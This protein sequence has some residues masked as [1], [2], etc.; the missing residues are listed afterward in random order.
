M[1]IIVSFTKKYIVHQSYMLN[2]F[3]DVLIY[4]AM[5][6]IQD[7]WNLTLSTGNSAMLRTP[8]WGEI[9]AKDRTYYLAV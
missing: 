1:D 9:S 2:E 7:S 3:Q 5:T 4:P 6:P 8:L